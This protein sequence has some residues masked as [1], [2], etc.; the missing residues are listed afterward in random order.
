MSTLAVI[1]ARRGSKGMLDHSIMPFCGNPLIAWSILQ[2][3]GS[4]RIDEVWVSSESAEILAV[5]T[6]YGAKPLMRPKALAM[7]TGGAEVALMHV[8]ESWQARNEAPLERIVYLQATSPLRHA[9]DIDK[10]VVTFERENAD[11]LF[12]ASLIKGG[13]IWGNKNG[14]Y[15]SVSYDHRNRASCEGGQPMMLE[16]GSIYI[17]KPE[18][19][20][21][22]RNRLGGKIAAHMMENWQSY[23]IDDL[24]DVKLVSWHFEHHRLGDH[25]LNRSL[26]AADIDLV[27]Y[28]FDGVMTDNTVLINQ[29]GEEQVRVNRSDGLGVEAIRSMG[30]EQLVLSTEAHPVVSARAAKLKMAA[31]QNCSNKASWLKS[32]CVARGIAL[33]RVLYIGNDLNDI[34]VMRLVGWP[35]CPADAHTQIKSLARIVL[36]RRG[37]DGI[38][39]ELAERLGSSGVGHL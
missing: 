27:V 37:G 1:L 30:L 5:A 22:E 4:E 8:V 11:S 26:T 39:Q 36:T 17:F 10:A 2:A 24:K 20:A 23:G 21:R 12:S 35:V 13:R 25:P 33:D 6:S 9:D 34:E 31:N 19:L 18:V 32:H 3:R 29:H 38:V 14:K 28:D 15:R 16:N 7:D